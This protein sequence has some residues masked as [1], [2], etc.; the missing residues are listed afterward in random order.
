MDVLF[1]S[2]TVLNSCILAALHLLEVSNKCI[3]VCKVATPLRELTFHMGSHSVTCHPA[4]VT[5][6]PLPQQKLVLDLATHWKCAS[7]QYLDKVI[8]TYV[9]SFWRDSRSTLQVCFLWHM[10]WHGVFVFLIDILMCCFETTG[11]VVGRSAPNFSSCS[12]LF[13]AVISV[14]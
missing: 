14:E 4:E 13:C 11:T 8:C 5:F 12:F 1:D 3:A 7:S 6:L 2:A 9:T 10:R